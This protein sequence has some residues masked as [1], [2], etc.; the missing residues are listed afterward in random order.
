MRSSIQGVILFS[1]N[2]FPRTAIATHGWL[3]AGEPDNR[4][5]SLSEET[6]PVALRA[7]SVQINP[8]NYGA[9]R[10]ERISCFSF[11]RWYFSKRG[12]ICKNLGILIGGGENGL[13]EEKLFLRFWIM[14]C[15]DLCG[16]ISCIQDMVSRSLK[17]FMFPAINVI[18]D[19]TGGNFQFRFYSW[20]YFLLG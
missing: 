8:C 16:D 19:S 5:W 12:I 13:V 1:I 18:S 2:F 17:I 15:W 11:S 3:H 10:N 7:R 14:F 6:I 4:N 20:F 9:D